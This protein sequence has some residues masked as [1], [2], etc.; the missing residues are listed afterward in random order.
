M[1]VQLASVSKIKEAHE[2]LKDVALQTPCLKHYNLSTKYN[3]NIYLKREDLQPVRSFKIR[4]A[5][6][7]I[8]SLSTEELKNG[9]VCASAGNHAQG[10]AFA[11]HKLKIKGKIFMPNPTPE[12]KI[13][14]VKHFGQEWVDI[15]LTGDSF[16][17]AHAAAM[18]ASTTTGAT[19]IH[20]FDDLTVIE[21]QGTVGAEMITQI[22]VPLDVLLVAVGGGGLIS[23]VG[24]Y[25]KALSP[26]T[27]IIA[28]EAAGANALKTSLDE[29]KLVTLDKIDTFA[30]GI[31][32]KKIGE[33]T[34]KICQQIVDKCLLVPEGK[35]CST[36][37][38][39]YNDEALVV[40]PAGA[41]SISAL[42]QIIEEIKGKNVGI[43]ICGGNNDI[44]RTQEIKERALLYEGLKHYFIITFPQRAGALK[45]FLNVLGPND[46]IA[47]FQYTKKNNREKGP[48]LVGI[49]LEDASDFDGLINRL[50]SKGIN[51]QH[52]N[53]NPVLF[54]MLV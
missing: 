28:V 22:D 23:G 49:E 46:D 18:Q 4:G 25:F 6:N 29:K 38:Q 30:D 43:I 1:D 9:I 52:L 12:Q 20:P 37:L 53:E 44:H 2:R 54:E 11:C 39:L 27:K 51:F 48:A 16:D 14:K 34:F 31:A 17:D 8:A 50:K 40:E 13:N 45:E 41:V 36:I 32:V 26:N 42:D 21:G 35:I 15:V 7:K 5:Y 3:C 19:L 24:S 10:V 47:H 33:T